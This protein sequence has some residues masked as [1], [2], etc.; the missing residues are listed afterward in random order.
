MCDH[1]LA[2]DVVEVSRF[3]LVQITHPKV[4]FANHLHLYFGSRS[5]EV[6]VLNMK[7]HLRTLKEDQDHL[8][9]KFTLGS[10]FSYHLY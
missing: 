6:E 1:E 7:V 10:T 9:S 5:S 2:S 8:H 4:M 3:S